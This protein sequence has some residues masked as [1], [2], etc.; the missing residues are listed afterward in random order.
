MHAWEAI[1]KSI[2]YIETHTT[3]EISI[4]TLADIACLS[5]YYYQRLFK[6]L[7]KKSVFEYTRLRRLAQSA[8]ALKNAGRIIDVATEYGFSSH[9]NFTRTFKEAFGITPD[10]YRVKQIPLNQMNKPALQLN[11]VL[12]DEGVP[13]IADGI[14]IEITRKGIEKPELYHGLTTKVSISQQIPVGETTGIDTPFLLWDRFHDIKPTMSGF[15]SDGV[16]IGVSMMED[17]AN[18]EF[19][20]FAGAAVTEKA[21][22]DYSL[23]AWELP[24]GEYIV[25][26]LEAE[27]YT[28]LVTSALGKAMSYILGIWLPKHKLSSK[29]F[30][31]EKYHKQTSES[32]S[33]EIWV[34]PISLK[35]MDTRRSCD[36]E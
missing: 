30:S 25:C 31:V 13:L 22:D 36:V 19:T 17:I 9:S 20:Y 15:A 8:E 34:A 26:S 33:M 4:Q 7:V 28:E 6:R 21:T 16:E 12:I 27:N 35:N 29:P 2:E 32:A 11:Y 3:E 23:T 1:Q 24:A 14:V 18:G 5:P 10:E